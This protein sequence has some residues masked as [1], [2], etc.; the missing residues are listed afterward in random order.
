MDIENPLRW[1]LNQLP[2][3]IPPEAHAELMERFDVQKR[4]YYTAVK[5]NDLK[6]R[7]GTAQRFERTSERDAQIARWKERLAKLE[8]EVSE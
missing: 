3:Y 1:L 7:I 5:I 8:S 4:R 2:A 6:R